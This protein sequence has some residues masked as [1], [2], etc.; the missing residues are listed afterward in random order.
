[1]KSFK[2]SELPINTIIDDAVEGVYIQNGWGW[3]YLNPCCSDC[4]R[5]LH[6]KNEDADSRFLDFG[7]EAFPASVTKYILENHHD[8]VNSGDELLEE[9]VKYVKGINPALYIPIDKA[10]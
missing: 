9:A 2:P 4:G 5:D 7:I 8:G 1:M 10:N 3:D 6:I